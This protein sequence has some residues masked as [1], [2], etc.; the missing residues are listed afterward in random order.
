MDNFFL[1]EDLK[2]ANLL[3]SLQHFFWTVKGQNAFCLKI[4]KTGTWKNLFF[5]IFHQ[6]EN[7]FGGNLKIM[8]IVCPQLPCSSGFFNLKI[9]M[10]TQI[11]FCLCMHQHHR[12]PFWKTCQLNCLLTLLEFSLTKICHRLIK[13]L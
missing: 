6:S 1:I 9:T 3:R 13:F 11:T 5:F 7:F 4:V 8:D 2:I 10:Q 12:I